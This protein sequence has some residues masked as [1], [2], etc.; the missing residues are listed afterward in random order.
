[1]EVI[2]KTTD[3]YRRVPWANPERGLCIFA[4]EERRNFMHLQ[5]QGQ[6][7]N[8]AVHP[9]DIVLPFTDIHQNMLALVGG[10]GANLG[11]M[12]EAGLPVP[13]S[14]SQL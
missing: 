9:T 12:A 10:K 6:Q 3:S 2:A 5:Q 13:D 4:Q 7:H 11:E 1:L 8:E 14:V